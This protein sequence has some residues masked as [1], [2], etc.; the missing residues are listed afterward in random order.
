MVLRKRGRDRLRI[1]AEILDYAKEGILKTQ[2]MYKANLS[3]LQVGEYLN[4]LVRIRCLGVFRK[5]GH[6]VFKTTEKGLVYLNSYL[7]LRGLLGSVESDYELGSALDA[8]KS[9]I[10]ALKRAISK[11]ETDLARGAKCPKCG[12]GVLSDF[13][14]CPYCGHELF[15][16][17][18]TELEKAK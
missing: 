2:L 1:M 17:P 16:A 18:K 15:G 4:L 11:L 7:E 9:D 5:G 6:D 10:M 8:V 3:F 14:L 13:R 12:R